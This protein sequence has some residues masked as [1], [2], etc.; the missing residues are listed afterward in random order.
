[1]LVLFRETGN[2]PENYLR[3]LEVSGETTIYTELPALA[4]SCLEA[5]SI[6]R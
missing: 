6:R 3:S 1:M 4:G 2:I 5:M